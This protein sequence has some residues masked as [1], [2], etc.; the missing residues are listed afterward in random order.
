MDLSVCLITKNEEANLS[1]TLV[2]VEGLADEIIVVDSG[3]TDKT[4]TIAKSFNANVFIEDWKGY[5]QQKNSAIEK[6]N[7]DWILL[8]DAD[9]VIT[10][11]LKEKI[12]S[13]IN[14]PKS[15]DIY[16]IRFLTICF[17][18]RIRYG[19]WSGF[20]RVRLFKRD[21]GR[22]NNNFVHE[23]FIASPGKTTGRIRNDIL[24]YTY[25]SIQD[26]I[27][28]SNRYTSEGAIEYFR[29][30]KRSSLIT[31]MFSPLAK[32]IKMYFLKLGFLDGKEGFILAI[33]SSTSIF[34][35]YVKLRELIKSTS[36]S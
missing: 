4:V 27:D 28:K 20:Y 32:F 26:Y 8:I 3:S 10:G 2:S 6:C 22:Y 7:G 14:Q 16:F 34:L 19:G 31:Q 17:G 9:E 12:R 30:G 33:L 29:R 21:A 1:R 35:K 18:K 13:M 23:S 25:L 11:Q 15:K 36:R 5:G 24:H